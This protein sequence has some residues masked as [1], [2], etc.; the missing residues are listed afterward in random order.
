MRNRSADIQKIID[1]KLDM[2]LNKM[3]DQNIEPDINILLIVLCR[4]ENWCRKC[5]K[6]YD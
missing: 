4:C 6:L 1:L 2:E 5:V 3:E